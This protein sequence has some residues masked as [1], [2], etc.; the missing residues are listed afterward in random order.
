MSQPI[1]DCQGIKKS[2]GK[3]VAI[4][5][6]NLQIEAGQFVVLL[7]PSGSGKSTL[8]SI[9]GGFTKPSEG[10]LF[11]NGNDVTDLRPSQRPTV[12]VLSL[13]HISEPTRPY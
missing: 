4:D 2:Y 1:V 6:L 5:T 12:T 3:L 11:I 7:G 9:L 8:L 10:R 13:I